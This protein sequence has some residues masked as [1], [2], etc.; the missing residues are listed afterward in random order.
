MPGTNPG[1]AANGWNTPVHPGGADEQHPN[2]V[3]GFGTF[4]T[5]APTPNVSGSVRR[6]YVDGMATLYNKTRK[7]PPPDEGG[8]AVAPE[9]RV[10]L[11]PLLRL[12]VVDLRFVDRP[13]CRRVRGCGGPRQ[14]FGLDALGE[15]GK[16]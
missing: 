15:S 16:L 1:V 11:T 14:S 6:P 13:R 2:H 5:Q 10:E 12:G 7:V 8:M 9:T 3:P 4:T